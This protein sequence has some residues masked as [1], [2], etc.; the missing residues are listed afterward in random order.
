MLKKLTK[1]TSAPKRKSSSPRRRAAPRNPKPSWRQSIIH[2][3]SQ[4]PHVAAVFVH[5]ND[6]GTC[7]VYTVVPKHLDEYYDPVVS[8][9]QEIEATFPSLPFEF[10]IRAHQNQDPEMVVPSYSQ[11]LFRR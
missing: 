10:R 3:F 7:Y 4:V 11:C 5:V 9:E 8:A 2:R 6:A 1:A